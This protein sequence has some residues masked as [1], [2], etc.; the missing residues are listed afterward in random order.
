[1]FFFHFI[2]LIPCFANLFWAAVLSCRG[3]SNLRPQNV[4]IGTSLLLA[5][6]GFIWGAYLSGEGGENFYKLEIVE[7]FT[8]L[9]YPAFLY[10]YYRT[11]TDERPLGWRDYL[12]LLPAV[13]IGTGTAVLY[14]AVDGPQAPAILYDMA[15]GGAS[16]RQGFPLSFRVLFLVSVTFFNISIR[17]ELLAVIVYALLRY[18]RY[19]RR[20]NDF[21]SNSENKSMDSNRAMLH[22]VF[23][24]LF[25][26]VFMTVGRYYYHSHPALAAGLMAVMGLISFAMGYNV[27]ELR[28][29]AVELAAEER[30]GDLEALQGGY[31]LGAGQDP[32]QGA[33]RQRELAESFD[34]LM[35]EERIFLQSDL[36]LDDLASRM[37]TN[38]TYLSRMINEHCGCS[39]S[40]AVNR[41]R[42]AWAQEL[43][44]TQRGMFQEQVAESSGFTHA[45]AFSRMFRQVT[46]MTCSDWL[47]RNGLQ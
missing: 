8:V 29:T 44:R 39:F 18:L 6:S 46:G 9:A 5:V 22:W 41:R 47:R 17:V 40:T 12:W 33:S 13:L 21:F 28:Y 42:I 19:R 35:D 34:R 16:Y 26:S 14:A 38:R 36:R 3:K 37:R 1:M 11:L 32:P 10:F 45:S 27:R 31:A 25:A 23:C 43:M 2:F 4:W 7:A 15:Q 20:L 30:R 24:F